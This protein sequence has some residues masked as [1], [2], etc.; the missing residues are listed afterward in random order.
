MM[1]SSHTF[2]LPFARRLIGMS[3]YFFF[4]FGGGGT[5]DFHIIR[6]GGVP[7]KRKEKEGEKG[8]SM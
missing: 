8:E 7:E 1:L 3:K 4:F 2:A 6:V 5:L